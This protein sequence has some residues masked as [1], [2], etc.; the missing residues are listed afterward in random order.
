MRRCFMSSKKEE[1]RD[2]TTVSTSTSTSP[3]YSQTSEHQQHAVNR[4]LDETKDN[5]RKTTDEARS[6]IPR[7]THAVNDYQEQTL[8]TARE[9]TDNYLESQKEI[10]NS[11]QSAWRPFVE[12]NTFTTTT[13]NWM[14]PRYMTDLYANI[15]SSFANNM[16]A[17]TRLATNMFFANMDAFKT[18]LQQTKDSTKELSRIGVNT[19]KTF[20]HT[21]SSTS[22]FSSPS[23]LSL[24]TTTA[25]RDNNNNRRYDEGTTT[26]RVSSETREGF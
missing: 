13:N 8:Q 18:T 2:E 12:N 16:I 22:P 11:L 1:R 25:T 6:Q 14:S 4:A 5:I 10:I 26:T 9:I 15:V 7:Y 19:A 21:T 24:Q 23:S 17:A 20:E 3:S